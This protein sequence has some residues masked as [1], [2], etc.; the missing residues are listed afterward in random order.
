MVGA[1][2]D[3]TFL[4]EPAL[5]EAQARQAWWDDHYDELL[6]RY[7]DQFVAVMKNEV[8]AANRDLDELIAELANRH[9]DTQFDADIEFITAEHG[10]LVL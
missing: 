4:S 3:R 8:V 5:A 7:P 9:P 2:T 6:T 1:M 10:S